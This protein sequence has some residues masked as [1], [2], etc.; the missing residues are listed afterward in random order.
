MWLTFAHPFGQTALAKVKTMTNLCRHLLAIHRRAETVRSFVVAET[1]A[2]TVDWVVLAAAVVGLGIGTVGAVRTGTSSTASQI[3]D[4]LASAVVG[5]VDFGG[6][7]SGLPSAPPVVWAP[8]QWD[9]HNPGI[10]D[11]YSAWMA[12]FSDSQLLAHMGNTE[13]F[14]TY[15]PGSGHPYDTYHD[16][17]FIARDEAITRGLITP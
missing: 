13:P 11:S 12:A 6:T 9:Q 17:Y 3:E 10:Y 2:V 1:G 5:D 4:S 14:S 16:E 15:P 7:V 8:M